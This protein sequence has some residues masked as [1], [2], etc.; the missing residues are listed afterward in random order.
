VKFTHAAL[1]IIAGVL[2][3][4]IEP[5][6]PVPPSQWATENLVVPDGPR[7]G[8]PWDLSLTPYIKEPL[9]MLGPES[10]VNEIAAMKGVQT[11]FTTLLIA[12]AGH[13]IDRDPCRFGILQPTDSALA[14][15]NREK[16]DPAIQSTRALKGKV[17]SQTSRSSTGS[18]TYSKRFPGG[19]LSL[20]L[21]SSAA[22]LRSKTL[23]KLLR[24]EIDQ[25]PDDLDGQGDPIDISDGRLVSFLASGDWKKADISTPTVK[26]GSKIEARYEQGDKRRWHVPCP[27]CRKDDGSPSE[28]VFEWGPYFRFNRVY[29]YQAHFVAPC[30]GVII[31]AH[32][33]VGL[34]RKGRWI[35]TDPRPGTFPSYHFDTLSSPFVPWDEIARKFIEAGDD[36]KKL[37]AFWNLWLGLPYEVKGDAPDHVRLMERRE[38]GLTKGHVPPRGLML[39]AAA[40]V[41]MR[42]IWCEVL[43]IAPDR[44]S[45]VVDAFYCDGSTESPEGEAFQKLKKQTLDRVFPDAFGRPRKLDALGVDS[46]YRSHVVYAWVRANQQLH[47]DTGQDLVLALD[48]RDGW[49]RPAIGT[50]SLVDINLAGHKVKQ[51][52]KLWP[53]GTW[54]LKG[55]AYADLH[56]DG[57]KSGKDHD[58]EGYCHFGMWLDESYF[59]QLTAEYL[60]EEKFKGRPRKSWKVRA[61]Q[62]DNHFLDCRVYNLALAEYLGLS[63]LTHD[64]WAWLA[65]SRGMP[66]GAIANDLFAPKREEPVLPVPQQPPQA[67][68]EKPKNDD[69]F[70]RLAALNAQT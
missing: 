48:G 54:P 12:A 47:P 60:A 46:G 14:D 64:E 32:E 30:C 26:G 66:E 41:Q 36:P 43:A 31:E 1:T 40:D 35:A 25:Y 6:A 9:D 13:T 52:C 65:K 23:K 27:H 67:A 24:D 21:A 38:D 58:P 59:R 4:T 29:P 50:P 51:G 68:P 39:V 20:L 5:P 8:E 69:I 34:V 19:S 33:K 55:A 11:G 61:S 2:A 3:L 17:A 62:P 7:A 10:G 56:K 44:Q 63:S 57:V 49:G 18:T 15:F 28:F 70:A 22:D 37:Q 42:G 53:V 16:L 45:Y